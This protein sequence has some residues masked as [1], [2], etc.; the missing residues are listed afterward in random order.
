MTDAARDTPPPPI[1]LDAFVAR[2][3]AMVCLRALMAVHERNPE[4]AVAV[5]DA[6][7][8]LVAP[9]ELTLAPF[10]HMLQSEADWWAD[11]APGSQVAAML[12]A[13]L[14]RLARGQMI[15]AINARKRAM[16]EI[17]NSLA[18]EDRAAFL[19]FA[20]PAKDAAA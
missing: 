11:C 15:L 14:R 18:P 5:A 3:E 10:S 12:A 6:F 8:D 2:E 4:A 16:V 20:Q 17:W 13:C 9:D 1:D 7:L 19:A